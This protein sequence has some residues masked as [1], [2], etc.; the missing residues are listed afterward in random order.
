MT[1]NF[2]IAL[3]KQYTAIPV[4]NHK[5]HLHA[6]DD[7]I[8]L[9]TDPILAEIVLALDVPKSLTDLLEAFYPK[10]SKERILAFLLELCK[11][12]YAK[13][14]TE[15][16]DKS[17][18]H[19]T[20]GQGLTDPRSAS[21]LSFPQSSVE[22][23]SKVPLLLIGDGEAAQA[24]FEDLAS[25]GLRNIYCVDGINDI[26]SGS[27]PENISVAMVVPDD[28]RPRLLQKINGLLISK[29]IPF[30]HGAIEGNSMRLGPTVPTGSVACLNCYVVRQLEHNPYIYDYE[31]YSLPRLRDP[32]AVALLSEK[33]VAEAIRLVT[34]DSP[35]QFIGNVQSRNFINGKSHIETLIPLFDCPDCSDR[36]LTHHT[37]SICISSRIK[38][39]TQ[40][41]GHRSVEPSTTIKRHR[42]LIG[43]LGIVAS[44]K[45]IDEFD[46][47][48][49]PV[50]ASYSSAGPEQPSGIKELRLHCGKG[51]NED[52]SKAS[53][54]FEAVER[55]C[56][57]S[58]TADMVEVATWKEMENKGVALADFSLPTYKHCDQCGLH[59]LPFSQD[60]PIEWVWGTSLKQKKPIP[61]PANL[62]FHGYKVQPG[63]DCK[64][65]LTSDSN[66]LA[67][68][69]NLE[70][71]IFHAVCEV[72]ER[73]GVT[74]FHRASTSALLIDI[75]K[76]HNPL[77]LYAIEN[78]QRSGLK[79]IMLY[80]PQSVVTTILAI[81]VDQTNQGRAFYTTGSSSHTDPEL[82]ILRAI[83]EANHVRIGIHQGNLASG[84][85]IDE[86]RFDMVQ[87]EK[88]TR[89][90]GSIQVS[91]LAD[92]SSMDLRDDITFI[93]KRLQEV[94]SD[95]WVYNLTRPGIDVPV[96]RV[97]CPGLQPGD[98][99]PCLRPS[100]RL[101]SEL[102]NKS[103]KDFPQGY[104][105]DF[106]W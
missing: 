5:I 101:K 78:I 42:H 20:V 18:D 37:T 61:I 84:R 69:N 27:F 17:G 60:M 95:I 74:L 72:I 76:V 10:I 38:K 24:I 57:H 62:V 82:A 70:E 56:A 40:D 102:Q 34:N 86:R 29:N 48:K 3:S 106:L 87:A 99:F 91:Q 11:Q 43:R 98:N 21:Q 45:R 100:R 8:F 88:L 31:N 81:L 23:F 85:Q 44:I 14:I 104:E 54:I 12:N 15:S 58:S 22:S 9:D 25:M 64:A 1:M 52:Q 55:Y 33:L 71:A 92:V 94:E 19:L 51:V 26:E 93:L 41:G 49:L 4:A 7:I 36:L 89:F 83:T 32:Q 90:N 30:I 65:F 63:H 105:D 97:I 53:A 28:F 80:L 75:D 16:K 35:P 77:V 68:G 73:D 66:G 6:G 50:F 47:V 13:V 39:H 103:L 96:V 2:N 79:L 67:A 46:S 59:C